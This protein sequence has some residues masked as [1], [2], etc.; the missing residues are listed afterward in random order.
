MV[1]DGSGNDNGDGDGTGDV[2]DDGDGASSGPGQTLAIRASWAS[3]TG[4]LGRAT[5]GWWVPQQSIINIYMNMS[6]F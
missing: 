2:N 3:G 6:F 4:G 1:T 5:R